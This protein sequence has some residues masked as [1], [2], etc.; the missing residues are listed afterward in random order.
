MNGPAGVAKPPVVDAVLRGLER[1]W[2]AEATLPALRRYLEALVR[3]GR[4]AEVLP[5]V[6]E[7]A[8][9]RLKELDARRLAELRGNEPEGLLARIL[10]WKLG[11]ALGGGVLVEV[12]RPSGTSWHIVGRGDVIDVKRYTTEPPSTHL[13][14][15][16][17]T[18]IRHEIADLT[19]PTQAEIDDAVRTIA[20]AAEA[21]IRSVNV[22]VCNL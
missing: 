18:D 10:G 22:L 1:S 7:H 8:A 20:R 15:T 3:A 17:P 16:T 11:D 13:S 6:I 21:T 12:R 5:L 19:G 2:K 4:F 9:G 14:I